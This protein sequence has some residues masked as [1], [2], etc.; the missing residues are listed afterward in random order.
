M[1]FERPRLM[2]AAGGGLLV[3]L[4]WAVTASAQSAE[5][6]AVVINDA[7]PES[8]EVGEYY[9]K[10]RAIPE[11]NVIHI[12]TTT[13]DALQPAA[14]LATIQGP[15]F[16][17]LTRGNLQDRIHYIVLT[18]GIPLRI[19][20][21]GGQDGT[22]ASVDSELALGYRRMT[23]INVPNRGRVDNPYYLGSKPIA[24]ARPFAHRD[25]DIYLVS[26]IDAF[27]TQEAKSL[28]DR[29]LRAGRE[30]RVV[31]DQRDALVNRLGEDWLGLAAQELTKAG[32]GERVVLEATPKPAR[33]IT[34][35]IG[36]YSWGSTDPQNR[37]RTVKMDFTPGAIAASFVS[38]D[39]RTLKEPPATWM[40]TNTTDK[41]TWFGGSPQSLIGDLIREG[42]TGVAGQVSEPY[43]QSAVRPEVLFPAYLAGFN[44]IEAFYLAIPHLSWQTVVVGD[45]LCAPFPRKPA[46]RAD[47]EGGMDGEVGLP[48]FFAK[49]RL[50]DVARGLPGADPKAAGLALRGELALR[51]GDRAAARR[52]FEEASQLAPDAVSLHMLIAELMT[53]S[54]ESPAAAERYRRVIVLDPNNVIALNNLAYDTAVRD[55][56]PAEALGMARKAM[57]LAPRDATV[58]DTVGWI[59]F[60][61]GNTAEA[62][63]L[64]VQAAKGAPR[65]PEVRL[66]NAIALAA[67]RAR[68]AAEAELAE[69]LKLQPSL[70]ERPEVAALQKQLAAGQ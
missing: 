39:A 15:I 12:T 7:S 27:T 23:G 60:L 10:Q 26:R 14:F 46:S 61:M 8:K 59:E 28:V 5:N 53:T 65:N 31:L 4:S 32:Q 51:G 18:K 62:S 42:V 66:H 52:L 24:D 6:V 50:A 49:R 1:T 44:L 64:L 34:P 25:H 35:V 38:T 21:T 68:G 57:S 48:A 16:V 19:A 69:A 43:L 17:A 55:K 37:V 63:K 40:P 56:K 20:G 70:Q 22:V 9:V 36:Y 41:A 29:S 47:L 13:D 11:S 54:G 58:L 3:L 33:E 45:P 67:Q 30:G 2:R